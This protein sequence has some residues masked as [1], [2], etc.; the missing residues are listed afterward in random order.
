MFIILYFIVH[1]FYNRTKSNTN[2]SI[3]DIPTRRLGKIQDDV[4][5]VLFFV[6]YFV[7]SFVSYLFEKYCFFVQNI[8]F[9]RKIKTTQNP[10]VMR[11][12]RNYGIF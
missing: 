1:S 6:K 2:G 9:L 4:S 3:P 7:E 12:S 10:I 8:D 11:F 5:P